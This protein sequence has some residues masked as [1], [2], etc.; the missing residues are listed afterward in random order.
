VKSEKIVVALPFIRER[1]DKLGHNHCFG[2]SK[3]AIKHRKLRQKKTF[4]KKS[5][6]PRAYVRTRK[7]ASV[8]RIGSPD[9]FAGSVRRIH[10]RAFGARRCWVLDL[11]PRAFGARGHGRKCVEK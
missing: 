3:N 4:Q 8:R 1:S 11:V 6:M 2:K 5:K 9:R 7:A 10:S